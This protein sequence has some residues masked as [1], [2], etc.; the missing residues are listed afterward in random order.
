MSSASAKLRRARWRLFATKDPVRYRWMLYL[1]LWLGTLPFVVWL[2]LYLLLIGAAFMAQTALFLWLSVGLLLSYSLL[3]LLALLKLIR[4][5]L[6]PHLGF[7]LKPEK[8][9]ALTAILDEMQQAFAT[10][11]IAGVFLHG[12]LDASLVELPQTAV[13]GRV[14]RYLLIGLP[15]LQCLTVA[16]LR[17]MLAREYALLH[18][19]RHD[20]AARLRLRRRR[21]TQLQAALEHLPLPWP[22]RWYPRLLDY[23]RSDYID[24]SFE[25]AR[26]VEGKMDQLV[27]EKLGNQALATGLISLEIMDSFLQHTFWPTLKHLAI[28]HDSPPFLPNAQLGLAMSVGIDP[29]Q[30]RGWLL[31]KKWCG[32]LFAHPRPPLRDRLRAIDWKRFDLPRL[33]PQPSAAETLLGRQLLH[34]VTVLDQRWRKTSRNLWTQWHGEYQ[35]QRNRCEQLRKLHSGPRPLTLAEIMEIAQLNELFAPP[36]TSIPLYQE[37]LALEPNHPEAHLAIGRLLLTQGDERGLPHLETAMH[38]Q[39]ELTA[40]GCQLAFNFLLFQGHPDE[41]NRY[42]ERAQRH[43]LRV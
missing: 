34:I 1:R 5:G 19:A 11:P 22:L 40:P 41:A 14:R 32:E 28:E 23:F 12:K 15:L 25:L 8:F 9:P 33:P 16:E 36:Q 17:A 29:N 2:G 21:L 6:L 20:G 13:G 26:Q 37:A 38:Y 43:C 27:A 30:A 7:H 3:S 10:P 24:A 18:L 4:I 31:E 42:E 35:Q 39:P